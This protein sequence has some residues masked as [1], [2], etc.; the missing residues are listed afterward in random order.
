M[1]SAARRGGG[2]CRFVASGACRG[3]QVEN[4]SNAIDVQRCPFL[5]CH[6]ANVFDVFRPAGEDFG[7]DQILGA[8]HRN[9]NTGHIHRYDTS[10]ELVLQPRARKD[11]VERH[12]SALTRGLPQMIAA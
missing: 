6:A 7:N 11:D 2:R 5:M 1:H 4:L 9:A 8:N 12:A 3:E 10:Q